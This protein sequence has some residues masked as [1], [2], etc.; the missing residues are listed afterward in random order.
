[1]DFKEKNTRKT[2]P[3]LKPAKIID[4][5]PFTL[6]ITIADKNALFKRKFYETKKS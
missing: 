5:T 2:R 1:M 3:F 4:K 6:Y